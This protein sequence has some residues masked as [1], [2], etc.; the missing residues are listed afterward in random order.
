MIEYD[1]YQE[2]GSRVTHCK[3][4]NLCTQPYA[5]DSIS[6]ETLAG[7]SR[8]K[9]C[10]HGTAW[11]TFYPMEFFTP[12]FGH[13]SPTTKQTY[14]VSGLLSPPLKMDDIHELLQSF[15]RQA[16]SWGICFSR[17]HPVCDGSTGWLGK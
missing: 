9:C 14:Y 2:Q 16:N 1:L 6:F 8:A 4:I 11:Y 13:S 12:K 15:P 17:S 10:W 7:E 3:P 5:T